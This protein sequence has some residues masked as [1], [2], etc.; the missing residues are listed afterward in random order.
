[1]NRPLALV[2]GASS[3]IGAA[4]AKRLAAMGYDL[5]LVARRRDRLE[6]HAQELSRLYGISAEAVVADLTNDEDLARVENLLRTNE[7]IAF[8]VNNAGFGT[9]GCFFDIDLESQR[10]MHK[11]HVMAA[12]ILT[13]AALSGMVARKKGSIINVSSL[14]AFS[15]SLGTVSY[16]ATKAWMNSFTEGIYLELQH[17]GSPVR[18]QAL[19]PGFTSSEFHDAVGM[20]R[21]RIPKSFWLMPEFVVDRSLRGLERNEAVVIPGWRYRLFA[22]IF[23]MMPLS[24]RRAMGLRSGRAMGRD[25]RP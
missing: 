10:Q 24:W 17:A 14:A 21:N 19:C 3:G 1:M 16:C 15:L 18:I 11:L 13:H 8:L 7:N 9:L 25:R 6:R 2:T 4:F 22:P 23:R 12:M 5:A 20:D